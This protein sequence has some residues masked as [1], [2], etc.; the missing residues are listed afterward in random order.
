M[1]RASRS[2]HSSIRSVWTFYLAPS[3]SGHGRGRVNGI[4]GSAGIQ[5]GESRSPLEITHQSGSKLWI[6]RQFEVIRGFQK[7]RHPTVALLLRKMPVEMFTHHGRMAASPVA[8]IEL[9]T[10]QDFRY[11]LRHGLEMLGGHMGEYRP[12]KWVSRHPDIERLEQLSYP[13]DAAGPVIE[14]RNIFVG[15]E[16]IMHVVD[17]VG[18]RIVW[19]ATKDQILWIRRSIIVAVGIV[20]FGR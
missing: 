4:L 1:I 19:C 11:E 15:H 20:R 5:N 17:H 18:G 2:H 16:R 10:T 7:E 12:Q 8:G 13:I 6:I 14:C 9:W 3:P